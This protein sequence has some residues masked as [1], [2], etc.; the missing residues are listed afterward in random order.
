MK[1]LRKTIKNMDILSK[2]KFLRVIFILS[3]LVIITY[4]VMNINIIYPVVTRATVNNIKYEAERSAR[5][6]TLSL[7]SGKGELKRDDIRGDLYTKAKQLENKL[8]VMKLK[9]YL[10]SGETIYSSSPSEIGEINREKYLTEILAKGVARTNLL[11][12]D[13]ENSEGKTETLYI[14]RTNVPILKD[15]SVIGTLETYYNIKNRIRGFDRQVRRYSTYIFVVGFA[16]MVAIILMAFI[17]AKTE[18]NL[19]KSQKELVQAKKHLERLIESSTDAIVTTD[20]GGMIVLFNKGA[21]ALT[22]YRREEVIGKQGPVLYESEEDAKEVMRRMRE[23]GGTVSAFETTFHAKD[24][25]SIPVL[26]S[27]SILYDEEGQEVGAVGF[28]K[29]L[30]ERKRAQEQL[31]RAEKMASV[32]L[33]TAGVS[34]EILN[35]LNIIVLRLYTM[36]SNPDTPP[37]VIPHLRVLER[38]TNRIAKITRDLLSFSRQRTPE[39]RLVDFSAVVKHTLALMERDL[40]LENIEVE[41]MLPDG[42]PKVMADLDQLEQVVLNLLTN[43]RDAMPDGG[44][45]TLITEPV[46]ANAHKLVELRVKDTGNGVAPDHMEKLFDPFFTTKPEGKGTGL[47]LA[48]CQGIV[49]AHGGAIWVENVNEGGTVFVVQ[50]AAKEREEGYEE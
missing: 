3:L 18:D 2:N 27:A 23:G 41:L 38:H 1:K 44:R 35:P 21:E 19:K 40:M 49:E 7:G 24:G 20:K 10:K 16:L 11:R 4:P 15:G 8:D 32:G 42:L 39:S 36:L 25:A 5:A 29:D 9:I 17:M 13:I 33:L 26:T 14:V 12:K 22:G 45:L 30:R 47:G 34:H 28:S 37:S 46:Q 50:L 48:I 43:A 31:I 6:I